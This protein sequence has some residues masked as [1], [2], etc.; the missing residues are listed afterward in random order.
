[1]FDRTVQF[2]VLS[3]QPGENEKQFAQKLGQVLVL[4]DLRAGIMLFIYPQEQKLSFCMRG[5]DI[6]IDIVFLDKNLRIVNLY[7]MA[8][9]PD[10]SGRTTYESHV[11]VMYAL[12]L[13]GG[14]I[15]RV[16]IHVG[17]IAEFLGVPPAS[18]AQPGL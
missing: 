12:E 10:R 15:K 18:C 1:M 17:D 8:V 9:E 14:T 7:E 2:S 3:E 16:G 4:G 6:P 13:P 11:P 5:C